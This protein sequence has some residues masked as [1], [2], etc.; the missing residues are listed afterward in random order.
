MRKPTL[1]RTTTVTTNKSSIPRS[2]VTTDAS[3]TETIS[4]VTTRSARS[5]IKQQTPVPKPI[6][7]RDLSV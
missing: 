4:L 1:K 3:D 7:G 6:P 5:I 2:P